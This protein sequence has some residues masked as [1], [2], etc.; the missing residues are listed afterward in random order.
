MLFTDHVWEARDAFIS[1]FPVEMSRIDR[2]K[3]CVSDLV[4]NPWRP[5]SPELKTDTFAC[6]LSSQGNA[7]PPSSFWKTSDSGT[8]DRSD[9]KLCWWLS[10]SKLSI[11]QMKS[12]RAKSF[13]ASSPSLSLVVTTRQVFDPLREFLVDAPGH[14]QSSSWSMSPISSNGNMSM[15]G[16]MKGPSTISDGDDVV[17]CQDATAMCKMPLTAFARLLYQLQID[18]YHVEV[19]N[20]RELYGLTPIAIAK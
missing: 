3:W 5:M 8:I 10:K 6:S 13:I 19:F 1:R 14:W 15:L 20:S 9:N 4:L 12:P 2:M 17:C 7:S 18:Q 11:E 16:R